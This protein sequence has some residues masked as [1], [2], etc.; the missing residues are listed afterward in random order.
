MRITP[1]KGALAAALGALLWACAGA[2]P[3]PQPTAKTVELAGRNGQVTSLAALKHGR[4]LY[5]G[6]CGECHE[7]YRPSAYS[8]QSWPGL[9]D[10]MTVNAELSEDHRRD[11]TAYLVA[12]SAESRDTGRTAPR[13]PAAA[14]PSSP[15]P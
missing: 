9:V 6:R 1:L 2:P 12:A 3:A 4:T 14:E 13:A 10:Q 7:L 15:Y 5:V 11:I 8:P